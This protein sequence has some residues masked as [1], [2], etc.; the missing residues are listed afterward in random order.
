[1]TR[2]I[3]KTLSG[4]GLAVTMTASTLVARRD[5]A[6]VRIRV[7]AILA[8]LAGLHVFAS[9]PVVAQPEPKGASATAAPS[10]GPGPA[11]GGLIEEPTY[12]V[13]KGP[14]G[15]YRLEAVIVRSA[16]ARGRLPIALITHGKQRSP[17][18]MPLMRAE[19]M[20]PQ[21]RDLA[22]RGYL[23]VAVVRRGF[24]R[25]DGTPGVAT[26]AP[27]ARCSVADLQRYFLVESD[28]IEA[29]LRVIG[30][31]ADADPARAIAIGGSVGG[32]AVLALASRKPKGLIAVVNI[33]GGMRLTDAKGALACP[34]ETP[35]AAMARYGAAGI[36]SLWLYSE[37]D[38]V[39][40]PATAR[41]LHD[42][43]V[44]AGG[45]AELHVVPALTPDGHNLMEL[46]DGRV[47]WLA[48]LDPFLRAQGLPTWTP[49]QVNAVLNAAHL[50]PTN[51]SFIEKY[52]SLYTP[53]V[54]VQMPNGTPS[55]TA[56]TRGIVPA[57]ETALAQCAQKSGAVCKVLMENFDLAPAVK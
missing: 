28:D 24:G 43:Y 1:M 18:E 29:S 5:A 41:R 27:Y 6:A 35:V 38:S 13:V 47:H 42:D 33:A 56:N 57:R 23:A 25:S 9:L 20:L 50:R 19:L 53:K 15:T 10:S 52:F 26:N 11:H 4:L 40:D 32:G 14:S 21:A 17:A 55:Y 31:R 22:H 16:A 45:K 30:E 39:F 37:N 7:P 54:L 8:I 2:I 49:S 3:Q 34:P 46:S 12:L 51:R 44:G 36:P 48:A